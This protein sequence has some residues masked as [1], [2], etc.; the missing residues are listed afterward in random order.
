MKFLITSFLIM[1]IGLVLTSTTCVTVPESTS[2]GL[3]SIG[4]SESIYGVVYIDNFPSN[5]L[6][7]GMYT[8]LSVQN[9]PL[10]P[11]NKVSYNGN[12]MTGIAFPATPDGYQCLM[13][14]IS[15]LGLIPFAP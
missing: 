10:D 13:D 7:I 9:S 2:G 6:L 4:G 11:P 15:S 8:Y 12:V 5:P 1:S 14:T 3:S